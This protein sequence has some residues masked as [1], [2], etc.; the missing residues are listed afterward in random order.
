MEK[1]YALT[2]MEDMEATSVLMN[3]TRRGYKYDH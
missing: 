3:L 1:P 2:A